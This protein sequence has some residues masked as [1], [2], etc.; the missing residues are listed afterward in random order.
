MVK[1]YGK[2]EIDP[3]YGWTI[4]EYISLDVAKPI[5]SED[6]LTII[7]PKKMNDF[8]NILE[9]ELREGIITVD[10]FIV[11][12]V[13]WKGWIISVFQFSQSDLAFRYKLMVEC[14]DL[15]I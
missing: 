14:N 9:N 12:K 6:R 5:T 10:D 2:P 1:K 11:L 13:S 15:A 4:P 8:C 3:E 7:I